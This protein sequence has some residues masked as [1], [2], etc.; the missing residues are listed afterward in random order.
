MRARSRELFDLPSDETVR[1]EVVTDVPFAGHADYLGERH[2]LIRINAELPI[3]AAELLEL[4]CH[5]AYPGHHAESVCKSV[6]LIRGFRRPELGVFV[7]PTPQAVISEGLAS[8]AREALLGEQAE[9]IAAS[10]LSPLDIPYDA[11][12]AAVVRRAEELLLP[13]RSNIALML[14]SG[15]TSAQAHDYAQAWLL[16]APE[17]I[18]KAIEHLE[19]RSWL[20]YESCYSVGLEL[21]RSYVSAGG[22]FKDLLYRQLTPSDL[23]GT[24]RRGATHR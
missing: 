24:P 6:G 12:T 15:S 10:A 11:D 22:G 13:V 20:P 19:A 23:S 9:E 7:Y 8:Y 18:N 16:D 17:H 21:C 14:S 1:W 4:V 3:S 2:T 5:E